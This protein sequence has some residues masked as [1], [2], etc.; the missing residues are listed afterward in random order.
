M[1]VH[2]MSL[3]T[4]ANMKSMS[5][6][7]DARLTHTT[8]ASPEST[9]EKDKLIVVDKKE[10][11][12]TTTTTTTTASTTSLP[13]QPKPIVLN[14]EPSPNNNNNKSTT[15]EMPARKTSVSMTKKKEKEVL[16]SSDD[17][18][19]DEED[20]DDDGA[21]TSSS[22]SRRQRSN[23]AI[24]CRI[25]HCEET[26]EEYLIAPCY[27]SGTLRYVHQSCLQQWLKKQGTKSCELCKFEFIMQ[28]RIRSLK[29][30]EKLDINHIE[31]RKILCS[32]MFHLIVITCVIWSLYVLIE[33]T[34]LEMS[35]NQ[36]DWAFW[37]KLV[38][39]AIGF[40]GG[41]IFMYIQCK[42]YVQLCMRWRRY[43]R[44]IIIQ[45]IT[46]ELLLNNTNMRRA[47]G[48][49]G[50]ANVNSA[51]GTPPGV[52][53][54]LNSDSCA[55]LPLP[56][57]TPAD[58][59]PPFNTNTTTITTT[60]TTTNNPLPLSSP[61]PLTTPPPSIKDVESTQTTVGLLNEPKAATTADAALISSE[62]TNPTSGDISNNH[63]G[64]DL[65]SSSSPS[66]T[67][68]TTTTT[69]HPQST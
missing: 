13:S 53:G 67:T 61:L 19:D 30:W 48:G 33:R 50:G 59:P 64:D 68:T 24:M 38:V 23:N 14:M 6:D 34:A 49:G 12:T 28:T 9:N 55:K 25:C 8:S 5:S 29:N 21:S 42:M 1:R 16:S 58:F 11:Q 4:P 56:P 47:G 26:S 15:I 10:S 36:L 35:N 32:V 39:V 46:E 63:H 7:D 27:C 40:T 45:P 31:R 18:D 37:V 65:I 52:V 62:S 57:D 60:T 51:S 2:E 66:T 54:T 17:D 44:V 3:E 69:Q 41:V 43:N 22:E 20:E